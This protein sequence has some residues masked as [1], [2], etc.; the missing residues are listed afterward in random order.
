MLSICMALDLKPCFFSHCPP[1]PL[2]RQS[3]QHSTSLWHEALPLVWDQHFSIS[4]KAS[5]TRR[6]HC[7]VADHLHNSQRGEQTKKDNGSKLNVSESKASQGE[8]S[9]SL[10]PTKSEEWGNRF[11]LCACATRIKC[12]VWGQGACHS[13]TEFMLK[14]YYVVFNLINEI[15]WKSS[16]PHNLT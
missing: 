12:A 1:F 4:Q 9:K 2:W 10:E 3:Q 8:W 15:V 14:L 11:C 13:K 7:A 5:G 6:K 16:C